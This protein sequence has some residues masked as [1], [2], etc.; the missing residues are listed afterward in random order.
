MTGLR[1]AYV[2][3]TASGGTAQHAGLLA[4]GSRRGGL[5]VTVL[6]PASSRSAVAAGAAALPAEA[7]T[8]ADPGAT[9]THHP[10]IAFGVAEISDRPRPGRDAAAVLTLRRLLGEIGPDVVHAHGL[11]AGACSALA[12]LR[13]WRRARRPALVVTIHNAPPRKLLAQLAYAV[14]E[15]TCAWRADAVLCASAD[16]A[17]R[18]RRR[19]A[20]NATEFDVPAA[21]GPAPSA[22]DVARAEA[23]IGAAGRPVILAAG[24]LAEQKGLDTLLAAAAAWQR[25]EP[26]PR[27]AIAGEGPLAAELAATASRAGLDLV[28]LGQRDDVPALLAAA[29]VVVVPSRWEARPLIVQEAMRAGRPI[30][31]SRVG[32]IP[33]LTGAEAAILV[34][35]ADPAQLAA[36][37]LA[38]L[39]DRELAARLSASARA[40]ARELPGPADAV[41]G[42]I[43]VYQRLAGQPGRAPSSG[44]RRRASGDPGSNGPGGSARK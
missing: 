4:E 28:L 27:L 23:D 19:G 25:R 37:V 13:P 36:A 7:G 3:G 32:G 38:V 5:Q 11:R 18:M 15:A 9:A 26:V 30:V 39:D 22:S 12:L 16:L 2:L 20:A 31:A 1:V 6:G 29:D 14:L 42:V 40:R 33:D 34:Q 21:R 44:R 43:A 35:P 10:A 24:R 41:A 17:A 8:P